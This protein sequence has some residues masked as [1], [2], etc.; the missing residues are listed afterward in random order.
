M[1]IKKLSV[2]GRNFFAS[3]DE[4][5]LSCLDVKENFQS[6]R[7]D[8]Q[9]ADLKNLKNMSK[10]KQFEETLYKQLEEYFAGK[11]KTF[12][13]KTNIEG[14]PFQKDVWKILQTIPFGETWS[15][16]K[17]ARIMGDEKK[18][19]AVA[20]AIGKN[21]ILIIVPCHRVIGSDGKLHGFSAGLDL[22]KQLLEVEGNE[23]KMI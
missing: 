7:K 14:T 20:N 13:I 11:R 5:G 1:V 8:Y 10:F 16:L 23:I 15:Y 3:F 6:L 4:D 19:R 9:N 21:P 2:G 18:V 12:N 17:V 22:K